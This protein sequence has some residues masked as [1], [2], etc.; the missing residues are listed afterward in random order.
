MSDLTKLTLA[1]AR[2]ALKKKEITSTELTG[3]YLGEMEAAS[4]LN[5]Y[6]TPSRLAKYL[7]RRY[8]HA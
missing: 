4:A 6:V 7:H 8:R 2:D 1:A 5:A 3:A